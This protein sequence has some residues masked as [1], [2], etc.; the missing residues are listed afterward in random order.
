MSYTAAIDRTNPSCFLF[1][2][3]QSGSMEDP[4]AGASKRKADSVADTVNRILSSL[5]IKCA[6][7]EGIRDYYDIGVIGYGASVGP[8][9][10]GALAGRNLVPIRE[11]ANSPAR[12]DERTKKVDD[13]AGGL[14]NQT[15]KFPIW[16][17]PVAN[18]G[19]PMC[20]ALNRAHQVLQEWV[21]NHSN[22]YPPIV[23]NI[24]DG[25]ATDGNPLPVA[26]SLSNLST[27]D[28]NVLVFNCHVSSSG[29]AP[30]IFHDNEA[31][32]PDE[33]A[34][35]LFQMSSQ[36]PDALRDTARS[37]DFKINDQAR[38][39]AFNADLE[40]LIRFLDIGTKAANLR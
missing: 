32:L 30:L 25:E 6:R 12:V 21:S 34:R 9:F 40:A 38:G 23:I 14:V 10:T 39:F 26:Q 5:I 13:G 18:G 17:D 24:T 19:T 7:G 3:D 37:E 29:D 8:A 27:N 22:S 2:I 28:G 16:F 35:L 20:E 15:V 33:Y 1:L 4:M 36:L 11:V 31:G